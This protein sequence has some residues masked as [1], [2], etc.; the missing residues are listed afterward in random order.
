MAEI[1]QPNMWPASL[2]LL[3]TLLEE[4]KTIRG[5]PPPGDSF[6]GVLNI[7][8]LH[9]RPC[10]FHSGMLPVTAD[11]AGLE[12]H[13]VMVRHQLPYPLT[14]SS[15]E[16]V[17]TPDNK[18]IYNTATITGSWSVSS[19]GALNLLVTQYNVNGITYCARYVF[20]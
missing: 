15:V 8:S 13:M 1:S 16:D 12:F 3:G 10:L 2:R 14:F 5:P 4:R 17:R 19:P 18:L 20:L 6:R 11:L 7:E 9:A